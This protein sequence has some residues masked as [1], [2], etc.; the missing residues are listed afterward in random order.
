[1]H[2]HTVPLVNVPRVVLLQHCARIWVGDQSVRQAPLHYRVQI[3]VDT[4]QALRRPGAPRY[5]DAPQHID[6][7]PSDCIQAHAQSSASRDD[8]IRIWGPI[9]TIDG[10]VRIAVDAPS[11]ESFYGTS[12]SGSLSCCHL[13]FYAHGQR[14]RWRAR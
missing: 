8:H 4:K 9:S 5:S 10:G 12:L 14:W 6:M 11:A 7:L 2:R 1:M 13:L 3:V